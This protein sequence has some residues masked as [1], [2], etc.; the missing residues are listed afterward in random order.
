MN[1]YN[2][3]ELFKRPVFKRDQS[4]SAS[5]PKFIPDNDTKFQIYEQE[6]QH[7]SDDDLFKYLSDFKTGEKYLNK[8]VKVEGDIQVNLKDFSQGD[9]K[10]LSPSEIKSSNFLTKIYLEL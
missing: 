9:D 6:V 7:L 3:D 4:S 2:P 1:N 10:N 8:L 5:E